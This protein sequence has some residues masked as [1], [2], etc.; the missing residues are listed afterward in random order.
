MVPYTNFVLRKI[1]LQESKK[2]AFAALIIIMQ[3][4]S[5]GGITGVV[6]PYRP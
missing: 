6:A 1:V 5:Q 2:N 3:W 4:R